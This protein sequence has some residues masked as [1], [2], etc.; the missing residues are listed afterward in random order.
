MRMCAILLFAHLLMGKLGTATNPVVTVEGTLV[1]PSPVSRRHRRKIC[2]S[3]LFKQDE[4]KMRPSS[5]HKKLHI[6]WSD[7]MC[8]ALVISKHLEKVL[9]VEQHCE[10]F[11]V[12]Q[13]VMCAKHVRCH[14]ELHMISGN[15]GYFM[16][17][18]EIE[19]LRMIP[20]RNKFLIFGKEQRSPSSVFGTSHLKALG[21]GKSSADKFFNEG[22]E[23]VFKSMERGEYDTFTKVF[24][25]KPPL[26]EVFATRLESANT[27]L[28]KIFGV[29]TIYRYMNPKSDEVTFF[30][31]WQAMLNLIPSGFLNTFH[32]PDVMCDIKPQEMIGENYPNCRSLFSKLGPWA[33]FLTADSDETIEEESGDREATASMKKLISIKVDLDI[34]NKYEL[35]DYSWLVFMAR[36]RMKIENPE[37][38]SPIA[39]KLDSG[40]FV[41]AGII[42]PFVTFDV[43][44]RV[45]SVLKSF[46][47][48]TSSSD[49]QI[50]ES[51]DFRIRSASP[52]QVHKFSEYAQK[53]FMLAAIYFCCVDAETSFNVWHRSVVTGTLRHCGT[54]YPTTFPA[55]GDFSGA[56]GDTVHLFQ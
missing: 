18:I 55:I 23:I 43:H 8:Q 25:D 11:D 36:P 5:N 20:N 2:G 48:W 37:D 3:L 47:A 49:A 15:G 6:D 9:E 17:R 19:D 4:C 34:L 31:H 1:P 26:H 53:Q 16:D 30:R 27:F 51:G 21:G 13:H 12:T 45:E 14:Y 44:R 42:D 28:P 32:S 41:F 24:E 29:Q 52:F 7:P 38:Y 10:D 33:P 40:H 54:G 46:R 50:H 56:V 39:T 35:V 22:T